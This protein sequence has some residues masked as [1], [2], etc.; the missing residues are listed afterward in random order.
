MS[1]LSTHFTR[2]I[3]NFNSSFN[4]IDSIK[5]NQEVCLGFAN[6]LP[7]PY[8]TPRKRLQSNIE[9]ETKRAKRNIPS[10]RRMQKDPM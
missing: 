3:N 6:P 5:P 7:N 8:N 2:L 9:R 10:F 4:T 1:Q